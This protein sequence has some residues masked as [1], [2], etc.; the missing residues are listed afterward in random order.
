MK[1]INKDDV[2]KNFLPKIKYI[3]LNLLSSLPKNVELDDLIQ[4]GIIG[5][6]Q[7][8]EK[9]NPQKGVT[10]YSFAVKRIRGLC[11]II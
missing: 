3:A 10:F 5:L 11:L 4:E 1:N 8:L 9:Y 2:I 7:S 6:L